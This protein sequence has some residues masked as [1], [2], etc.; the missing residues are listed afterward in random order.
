MHSWFKFFVI[1][2]HLG[3]MTP[4]DVTIILLKVPGKNNGIFVFQKLP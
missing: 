2:D 3:K 1:L 4:R